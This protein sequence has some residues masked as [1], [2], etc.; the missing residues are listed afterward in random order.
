MYLLNADELNKHFDV[1]AHFY[2]A[3][4]DGEK[5]LMRSEA[6]ITR[7][8]INTD[9]LDALF[10]MANPG[11]CTAFNEHISY[12]EFSNEKKEL[13]HARP[14]QTQYQLMNLMERMNWDSISLINVSD[15]CSGNFKEFIRILKLFEKENNDSHSLF[16][17]ERE[18]EL[19]GHLISDPILIYAWGGNK[20]ISHL[21]K[22]VIN[23]NYSHKGLY[24]SSKLYYRH[25]RPAKYEDRLVWVNE[26]ELH[27]KEI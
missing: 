24:N 15:I 4:A 18:S 8:K 1:Q 6:R 9:N 22:K 19:L 26:M 2:T 17:K 3:I 21:T 7:R 25:P 11:G 16:A 13:V 12:G 23:K 20:G 10:V 27:L 14:D 5:H